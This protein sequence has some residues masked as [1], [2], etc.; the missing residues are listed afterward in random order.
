MEHVE[1]LFQFAG[2]LGMF[3]YGMNVMADGLQKSAGGRMKN[4]LGVLTRNRFLGILVGAAVTALIQSSSA[5]TVMVV[6][7][8]NA[9]ILNLTQAVGVIMGANIGTT[10]TAWIV[11]MSEWGSVLKPEFFAP[12]LIGIGAF[13]MLSGKKEKTGEWSEILI[14]FGILFIGLSFMS[15][16]VTPYR[17]APIFVSWAA[18]LS[19]EF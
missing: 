2:G 11:S 4:L 7:F 18:I 9:G 6:G 3:L 13:L 15:G 1:M 5:A 12:L 16:A 14:G 19:W 8:V 10:V 17:D